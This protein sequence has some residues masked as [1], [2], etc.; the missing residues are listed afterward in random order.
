MT[1]IL[2]VRHGHVAGINPERFR[3]R[4]DLT[5]TDAGRREA[6]LTARRIAATWKPAAIYASPLSRCRDT[7]AAIGAP[8][9]VVPAV[10]AGLL[11]IDYG[12]WQGLTPHEA[13]AR[14][15]AEHDLWHQAP[16]RATIP[17][18]E[19]LHEVQVRVA[20]A[21]EA[22]HAAHPR[23]TVVMVGHDSV[24]RIILLH[25]L[26]A[27]LGNYWRIR[28]NPCAINEIE[29]D[30]NGFVV[31]SVNQTDHLRETSAR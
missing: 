6:E 3:G 12:E 14:W 22:V 23:D 11:D 17:G 2:L 20:A 26:E 8:F 9:G 25:A 13:K 24:N 1:R 7:G 28:Q 18:G 15:P 29:L 16:D 30:E 19:T 4:A 27:P 31:V 5:L 10:L 21:L